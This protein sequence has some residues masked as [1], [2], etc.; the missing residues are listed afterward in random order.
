MDKIKPCSHIQIFFLEE[1]TVLTKQRLIP[2]V[3]LSK[4]LEEMS[5]YYREKI[6]KA[7]GSSLLLNLNQETEIKDTLRLSRDACNL[8]RKL[9]NDSNGLKWKSPTNGCPSQELISK[10]LA[11]YDTGR[12]ENLLK[13]TKWAFDERVQFLVGIIN[14]F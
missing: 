6:E 11:R 10:G 4:W 14:H 12:G 2:F 3:D 13:P 9:L 1:A 8:L 5:P 7:V